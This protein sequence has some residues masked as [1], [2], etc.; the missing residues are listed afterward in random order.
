M[1]WGAHCC[2]CKQTHCSPSMYSMNSMFSSSLTE[3][4]YHHNQAKRWENVSVSPDTAQNC[5]EMWPVL[6]IQAVVW[7]SKVMAV[8]WF[9][10]D[11][12][13]DS[14]LHCRQSNKQ[15]DWQWLNLL[16][17]SAFLRV[18]CR[19]FRNKVFTLNYLI[20]QSYISFQVDKERF[21]CSFIHSLMS[22]FN[23][24]FSKMFL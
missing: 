23:L 8:L 17:L 16:Q 24:L 12:C 2:A 9:F 21:F 19:S 1:S 7:G 4:Y 14:H 18:S 3:S 15:R 20:F 6:T 10:A 22:L 5:Q 13:Q 11:C